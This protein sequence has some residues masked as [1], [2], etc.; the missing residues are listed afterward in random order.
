MKAAVN[1]PIL[2]PCLRLGLFLLLQGLLKNFPLSE[3]PR[4]TPAVVID[5]TI[6]HIAAHLP[7]GGSARVSAR[8]KIR[9]P[10]G[11]KGKVFVTDPAVFLTWCEEINKKDDIW[12]AKQQEKQRVEEENLAERVAKYEAKK[13]KRRQIVEKIRKRED[14][15]QNKKSPDELPEHSTPKRHSAA[16]KELRKAKD[17]SSSRG[18]KVKK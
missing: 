7:S 14:Q 12:L 18:K 10:S 1:A 6:G 4:K 9:K 16:A 17:Q 2:Q 8:E 5:P 3:M 13:S 15:K 11:K